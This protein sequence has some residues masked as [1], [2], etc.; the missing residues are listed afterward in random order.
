MTFTTVRL[1]TEIGHNFHLSSTRHGCKR[2]KKKS[3]H[4]AAHKHTDEALQTG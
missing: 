2:N 4:H 3:Q 1:L